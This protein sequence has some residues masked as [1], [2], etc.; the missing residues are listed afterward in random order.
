MPQLIAAH[1]DIVGLGYGGYAEINGHGIWLTGGSPGEQENHIKTA[2]SVSTDISLATG[3]RPTRGRRSL[4]VS[5]QADLTTEAVR[6]FEECV[7]NIR[8]SLGAAASP[9]L[10]FVDVAGGEGWTTSHAYCDS[11]TISVPN[12]GLGSIT[13]DFT[14]WTFSE[15]TGTQQCTARTRQGIA[16]FSSQNAVIPMWG[17]CV[18]FP[19]SAQPGQSM[20]FN[21]NC[22]NNWQY[23]QLLQANSQPPNPSLVYPGELAIDFNYVTLAEPGRRPE[24][25]NGSA[26]TISFGPYNSPWGPINTT[27][28][29]IQDLYRDPQREL[30][31]L[32]EANGMV[33]WNVNWQALGA[34][35]TMS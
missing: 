11:V 24:C 20:E 6:A 10:L 3:Q 33:H 31:S 1:D 21:L 19:E 9:Q 8:A 32:G 28:I 13:F 15:I 18:S 7:V 14:A 17:T 16:S 34:I 27:A 12:Q 30:T 29:T 22:R 2:G 25:R 5:L 23:R 4:Q 26:T 35:P